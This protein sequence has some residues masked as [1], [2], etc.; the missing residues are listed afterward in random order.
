M[1]YPETK[2]FF[3]VNLVS[4]GNEQ[5][6]SIEKT[7]SVLI[8]EEPLANEPEES[9]IYYPNPVKET[10]FVQANKLKIDVF[11]LIAMDGR[12]IPIS[13][14]GFVGRYEISLRNVPSGLYILQANTKTKRFT[15]RIVVD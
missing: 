5:Y 3:E 7:I 15:Y 8:M 6:E 11:K 10:L 1:I 4:E 9:L 2:K 12:E 14:S 13:V